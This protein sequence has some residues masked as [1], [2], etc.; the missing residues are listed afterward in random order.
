MSGRSL[1]MAV[2]ASGDRA[3]DLRWMAR[4]L[5]L[6]AT[7]ADVVTGLGAAGI[8]AI[9]LKGPVTAR[10]QYPGELRPCVDVDLLVPPDATVAAC[11][12]LHRHGFH[13]DAAD[14]LVLRRPRDGATVDLHRTL[15]G[16]TAIPERTWQVLAGHAVAFDLHG[17]SVLALDEAA[18]ACHLALHAANSGN[19]KPKPRADLDRAV[20]SVPLP[21]WAQALTIAR[22]LGAEP[23]LVAALRCYAADGDRVADALGLPSR[24][25]FAAR[26]RA[27]DASAATGILGYVGSLPW[28][29]RLCH[30]RTWVAPR[31]SEIARRLA[32]PDT[33]P[34]VRDRVPPGARHLALRGWQVA[35]IARA[36]LAAWRGGGA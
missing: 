2:G 34:W 3:L 12:W 24:A 20:A 9:V 10:R 35:S 1:R 16:A 21:T 28:R 29:Q 19:R 36:L 15:G 8:T 17:R 25:A 4:R 6:E 5:S 7:A 13:A 26:V 31:P 33:P 30:V 14:A 27:A 11:R 18:H 23:T 22:Q 32:Q